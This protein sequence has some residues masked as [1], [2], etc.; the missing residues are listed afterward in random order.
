[1]SIRI[2]I[3]RTAAEMDAVHRLRHRVFA[4]EEGLFVPRPDGRVADRF[5][6]LAA[7]VNLIAVDGDDV[8]G[9]L[10][11]TEPSPAGLPTDGWFDFSASLPSDGLAGAGSMLCVDRSHRGSQG[12]FLGLIGMA[13]MWVTSRGVSHVVGLF[14]PAV[15]RIFSWCGGLR[16]AEPFVHEGLGLPVVA[17]VIDTGNMAGRINAF[18]ERQSIDHFLRSFEREFVSQGEA[19][20]RAGDAGQTA[21][22]VVNGRVAV[23]G[24][25]PGQPAVVELG[26]GDIFGELAVLTG[27]AR[28]ASVVALTDVDLMVLERDALLGQIADPDTA[29]RLLEIV[30]MRLAAVNS[31]VLPALE[32]DD[33]GVVSC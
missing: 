9:A 7:T 14:N 33:A 24:P 2:K 27:R 20:I 30:A 6:E 3:A 12:V 23:T 19:I 21:Y 31:A 15:E 16:V 13:H 11:L 29:R 17:M 1:M 5:D 4:D 25:G 26:P 32:Q 28:S 22:V 8:V 10:R 18:V